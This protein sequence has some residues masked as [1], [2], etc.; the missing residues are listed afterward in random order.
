MKH[1][2]ALLSAALAFAAPIAVSAQALPALP[3]ITNS[4]LTLKDALR[5]ATANNVTLKQSEAD[6][7]IAAASARSVRAQSKPSVSAT[8]YGTAGDSSN[9]LT[10]SPAVLP[11]N[12]F[13]V[14]P[15]GFADQNLML[16]V[17]LFTGGRLGQG[18]EA[19]NRQREAADADRQ[20]AGLTVTEAVTE[21]YVNA[22]LQ[23]ALV[24][25]AQTRVTAEDE[26]VRETAEKVSAGRLAPVD[27]LREQAEQ[28]DA[29][30][31]L[32][33][34]QN[35]IQLA[36]ISLKTTLGVSQNSSIIL[37]D[38]LDAFTGTASARQPATLTAALD[39]AGSARPEIAAALRRVAAAGSAAK[40][41]QGAYAPQI[42]GVAMADAS[43]G[44]G[45]GRTGYTVSLTASLP[46]Y[47]G[48]QRRAETDA[49]HSRLER[50]QADALQ[51]RQAV[52]QQVATAWLTRETVQ[53]QIPAASAGVTAAQQAYT[54]AELRYSAGKSVSA[55]RLA[56][57]LA[58]T[59]AQ[60]SLAQAKASLL[61]AEARLAA[62]L[63][64]P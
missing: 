61:I 38:T 15:H 36:L 59:R 7:Q 32:L 14:P 48:G 18:S 37:A 28:A 62:A 55:D 31:A 27:L 45:V 53:A 42:Y 52:D 20:A 58:L 43:A 57:L 25:V 19:A 26:Q 50:A 30:Q 17:P 1:S 6:A 49:A 21:G 13:S 12:I 9:I 51:A 39:E 2:F 46:L 47:D 33:A 41:A 40:A 60:G 54:L 56:A 4:A 24:T 63:G 23:S 5:L 16:M 29:N 11:Q 35:N 64:K 44:A 10:T 22:L 34:A 3:T 8:T